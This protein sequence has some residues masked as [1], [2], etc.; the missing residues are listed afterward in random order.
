MNK[1]VVNIIRGVAESF[2]YDMVDWG[3][4]ISDDVLGHICQSAFDMS[5]DSLET[6]FDSCIDDNEYDWDWDDLFQCGWVPNNRPK[7]EI[8]Y[9]LEKKG[10]TRGI[11][12]NICKL[13]DVEIRKK[14]GLGW[15]KKPK[16]RTETR[17]VKEPTYKILRTY[18]VINRTDFWGKLFNW[19][20][21]VERVDK[22]YSGEREIMEEVEVFD[23]YE[24]EKSKVYGNSTVHVI[25]DYLYELAQMIEDEITDNE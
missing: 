11:L 24:L 1:E 12:M 18:P 21:T 3:N 9:R 15:T 19:K 4:N 2:K 5:E 20:Q 8:F 10:F 13:N 7:I 25:S 16:Y 14:I 22:I 23:G 6:Y 17:I